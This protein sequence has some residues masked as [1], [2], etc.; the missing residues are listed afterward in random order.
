MLCGV[1]VAMERV[2]LCRPHSAICAGAAAD[3]PRAQSANAVGESCSEGGSLRRRESS[4]A[5]E[6]KGEVSLAQNALA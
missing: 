4:P 2:H 3:R 6:R 5:N 1:S